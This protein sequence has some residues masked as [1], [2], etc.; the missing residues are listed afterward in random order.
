MLDQFLGIF[1]RNPKFKDLWKVCTLA[2]GLFHGQE[3]TEQGFNVNEDMLVEN[4]KETSLIGQ[5][6]VSNHMSCFG[7]EI[8]VV[9]CAKYVA[10]LEEKGKVN[11][12]SEKKKKKKK[13]IENCCAR[14]LPTQKDK[15]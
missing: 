5:I 10:A 8:Q 14:K 3:Q 11:E 1:K 6:I 4:L 13:K 15:N 12:S 9:K 7:I 2:F